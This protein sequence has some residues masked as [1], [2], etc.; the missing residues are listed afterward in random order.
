MGKKILVVDDDSEIR[1]LARLI[2]SGAGYEVATASSGLGALELALAQAPDLILLDVNMPA[3]DGWQ[4][5]RLLKAEETLKA[6]PVVM[7][8]VKGEVCD[9]VHALQDGAYDYIAKPF[10]YD[11]LLDRIGR[12]FHSLEVRP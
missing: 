4:A 8:T 5:L 2:L 12:I 10:A 11:E 3:M 6:L 9:K 1:D 7:F